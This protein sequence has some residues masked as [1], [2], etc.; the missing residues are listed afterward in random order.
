MGNGPTDVKDYWEFIYR[1]PKLIG[2]CIW[3]WADHT[4]VENNV[5]KYGG[6]FGEQT[7]DANFCA[8][9]IVMH[10]RV[11]ASGSYKGKRENNC[12]AVSYG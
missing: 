7:H 6:D 1:Y 10:D 8:D 9:G 12:L 3:E 4:Y 5:P 11:D 2:G